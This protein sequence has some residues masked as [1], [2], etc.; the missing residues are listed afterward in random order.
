LKWMKGYVACGLFE[1]IYTLWITIKLQALKC[2]AVEVRAQGLLLSRPEVT[3]VGIWEPSVRMV[4]LGL[5]TLTQL[6]GKRPQKLDQVSLPLLKI[7]CI[8]YHHRKNCSYK[9]W[10]SSTYRCPYPIRSIYWLSQSLVQGKN[11]CFIVFVN[12]LFF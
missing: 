3:S 7:I 1:R 9:S 11:N 8:K 12:K 2:T 5:L 6:L 4:R 10:P